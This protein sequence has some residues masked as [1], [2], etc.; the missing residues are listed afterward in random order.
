MSCRSKA[1]AVRAPGLPALQRLRVELQRPQ[2]SKPLHVSALLRGRARAAEP[3]G[4]QVKQKNPHIQHRTLTLRDDRS[5]LAW[6]RARII[7]VP[8][9]Q[10]NAPYPWPDLLLVKQ[11]NRGYVE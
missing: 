7:V 4:G 5:T 11:G 10:L 2:R 9:E 6:D 8:I 3:G 1:G